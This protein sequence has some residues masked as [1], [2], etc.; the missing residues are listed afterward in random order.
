M[1]TF[2]HLHSKGKRGFTLIELLVTIT[3]F[4]ILTGVVLFSQTSFNNT[5]LLKNLAYDVALTVRQAQDYGVNVNE[6]QTVLNP[7]A[8]FGVYF[9]LDAN[10]ARGSTHSFIFFSD[11]K[12]NVGILKSDGSYNNAQV[13]NCLSGDPECIS[14]YNIGNGSYIK[15][16][17][18]G[19]GA[20]L[21][22]SIA[23]GG[24]TANLTILFKRPNPNAIITTTDTTASPPTIT[25]TY[26]YAEITV[27]SSNGQTKKIVVTSAGQ[28]YVQ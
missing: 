1:A 12:N 10:P 19:S 20:G 22:N 17:C 24:S 11:T 23:N 21:C 15:D 18:V 9:N 28:I 16:I 2:H 3:I 27:A 25:G 8:P 26:P 13:F 6:S 5:V 14:K 7:F 4:V